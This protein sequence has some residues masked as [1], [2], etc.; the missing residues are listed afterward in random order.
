M[1][2]FVGTTKGLTL[3]TTG[4]LAKLFQVSA[5]TV[6]NWL[7]QG[8]M[9]FE[10]IG[11]GPRRVTE[12]IVLEYI[13]DIGISPSALDQAIYTKALK[14]ANEN[15]GESNELAIVLVNADMQIVSWNEG[16]K[17]LLE[18]AFIDVNG[19]L[20]TDIVEKPDAT[21]TNSLESLIKSNWEGVSKNFDIVMK[22]KS[23]RA[24]KLRAT[25]SKNFVQNKIV[26]YTFIFVP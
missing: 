21:G 2:V 26:G 3:L 19:R 7:I 14:K 5:Q 24:I 10:R 9:P 6:I 15:K 4:E 8:R 20:L 18:W 16:S 1:K 11:R 13:K 22:N 12:E 17:S 25:V 23:K